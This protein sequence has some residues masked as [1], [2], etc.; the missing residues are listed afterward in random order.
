[1]PKDA[2]R[3]KTG[4]TPF[5]KEKI[6]MEQILQ[7]LQDTAS[8]LNDTADSANELIR[9]ANERLAAI[10]SG[11]S[12]VADSCELRQEGRSRPNEETGGQEDAGYDAWVLAYSKIHGTWQLGVQ[13]QHWAPGTSGFS[14]DYDMVGSEE[15]PLL[16]ADREVRIKAAS[17]LPMFLQGYN[18]HLA[19][20]ADELPD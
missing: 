4:G 11:V 2:E 12:F 18:A 13:K 1:M 9:A 19:K 16:N 7:S 14:G 8:R 5:R 6:V 10:G 3:G 20:L 15:E 17:M